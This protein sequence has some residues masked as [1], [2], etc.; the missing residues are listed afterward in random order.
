MLKGNSLQHYKEANKIQTQVE[1]NFVTLVHTVKQIDGTKTT[2][3]TTENFFE[4]KKKQ[5]EQ[6]NTTEL[7]T[8]T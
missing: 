5:I 2:T 1:K 8:A 6:Q 3:T 4:K 7:N